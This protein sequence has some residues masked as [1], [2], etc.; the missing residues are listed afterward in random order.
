[1]YIYIYTTSTLI[2][3]VFLFKGIPIIGLHYSSRIFASLIEYELVFAT[4]Y[5]FFKTGKIS[6]VYGVHSI[7]EVV[8]IFYESFSSLYHC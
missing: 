5:D 8:I 6:L 4:S 3:D 2:F 1:M 7:V